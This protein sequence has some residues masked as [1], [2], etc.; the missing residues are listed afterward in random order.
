MIKFMYMKKKLLLS[1]LFLFFYN[2]ILFAEVIKNIEISGNQRVSDETIKVYGK[3]KT[4]TNYNDEDYNKVLKNLYD[5]GFFEEVS[6]SKENSTLKIFVKEY[7]TINQ[8]VILGVE[9]NKQKE[10]IKK[11]ILS[12]ENGTFIKSN[13]EKD[14][15]T[16]KKLFSSI[17]H[18]FVEI[19]TKVKKIDDLNLDLIVEIKKG[20]ISRISS[21]NFIGDKKV[22][23]NRLRSVVASEEDKFWKVISKNTRFSENLVQ[24]DIR[25][26]QNY[27]RSIGFRDV[28][29]T[30]N[31]ANIKKE[32]NVDLVYSIDAGKRYTIKKIS[33]NLDKVFDTKLFF[34]L[35]DIYKE[36]VGEFYSPFKIK[37][38]LESLDELIEQ[39]N[40][41]FVDHNVQETVDNDGINITFNIFEGEKVLVERIDVLGNNITNE[42]VIRG[43]LLLDE[44]DPYTQLAI[45]KSV[46]ELRA[47]NIFK[48][49]SYEVVP[50]SEANLKK[51]NLT[52]EEKA[53]GEISAGA[54]VGT[55]GGTVAF[56]I[57]ENNWLGQGKIVQFNLELDE[58][59]L[60]GTINYENPNYDFLG[61]SINYFLTS[62]SND[63]PDKGYE[64]SVTA[65]GVNTSFEQ[66]KDLR[67]SLGISASYDDLRTD[68]TASDSIKKQAGT[69]SEILGTYGFTYDKRNRAFMPTDGSIIGF[70]QSLPIVV[71]EPYFSNSFFASKYTSLSEDVILANKLFFTNVNSLGSEDVRLNKRKGLSSKRLRGF[72]KNKI[73]PVD[74]DDYVGGNYAAAINFEANLPNLLPEKT[75]TDISLFLDFGNVWG[76]DYDSSI[77]DSNTIRSSTGIAAS[78][79]SPIGP[80]TFT[81]SQNLKKASTDKT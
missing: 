44:G 68:G 47:R 77:D 10:Q 71:D 2:S 60:K 43:E 62:E 52:V 64:N 8:L 49:V 27:Y 21:I 63:K 65:A 4:N 55:S 9:S 30:S 72:E 19:D 78:W 28:K 22:R 38:M 11:I 36:Y 37:K 33:T 80:M 25:L 73:G 70:S 54:G 31:S 48:N 24:L 53:T 41:Q 26:L 79:L 6:L 3:L 23:S 76:V 17:G 69:F 7:P 35:E 15:N 51:I 14:L 16:I 74:S 42:D 81:L 5:T 46:A 56:N 12:K 1:L 45:E 59:Q 29:V 58:E 67:A 20:N 57:K 39:N 40:L 34:P 75:N 61:N 50:G 66:Y 13:L 18:N 32:G